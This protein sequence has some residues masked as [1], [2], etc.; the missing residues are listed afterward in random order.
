MRSS[1][2]ILSDLALRHGGIRSAAR[3][4]GQPVSS[5]AAA[6]TRLEND[7]GFPLVRRSEDGIS[8]TVDA[9][10][11]AP[12]LA[13]LAEICRGILKCEP[14][15]VPRRTVGFAALF[16]FAQA[17]RVGS[18]RRAAEQMNLA[19]PQ[20]T[21]QI[22]QLEKT[23]ETS[24]IS[25]GVKGIEPTPAGLQLINLVEQLEAEWRALS[26]ISEPQDSQVSR[27]YA[28]GS[29]V[30]ATPFGELASLLAN[31]H[32]AF[33]KHHGLNVSI[34]NTLA[35]DLLIGLD[36]GRFD[37]IL[38][39]VALKDPNYSQAPLLRGAVAMA[40]KNIPI[41][42][43][44]RSALQAA[45]RSRPLALQSRRS[46]LRQLS[47][48]FLD[49]FA[50]KDWRRLTSL[51]EIDSLPII[52]N[53]VHTDAANSIL[54]LHSATTECDQHALVLPKAFEQTIYLTWRRTPRGRRFSTFIQSTIE[55]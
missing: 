4:S 13:R 51:V 35:E 43:Q 55:R 19:Q 12:A 14:N 54:P 53:M 7:L 42:Y 17:L 39:D 29:I 33:Y 28:L 37:C 25:R 10:R 34:A 6:L 21:R 52:V 27:R 9:R 3:V 50:G 11:R 49:S 18:I 20:L 2:I 45:L 47:E 15:S 36:T 48:N 30:P 16:R 1:T 32:T 31:L 5:I 8:L 38:L 26:Y 41:D 22:G 44:D 23:L 40:G 46:G 24:L